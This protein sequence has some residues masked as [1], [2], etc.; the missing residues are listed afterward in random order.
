MT[1][2]ITNCKT[3]DILEVN[4]CASF[5]LIYASKKDTTDTKRQILTHNQIYEKICGK[6]GGKNE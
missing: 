3:V 1:M 4:N 5:G 6:Q 2:L